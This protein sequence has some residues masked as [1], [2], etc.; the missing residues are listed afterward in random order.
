MFIVENLYSG[1]GYIFIVEN[2]YTGAGYVFVLETFTLRL[3]MCL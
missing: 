1:A 2:L 3:V